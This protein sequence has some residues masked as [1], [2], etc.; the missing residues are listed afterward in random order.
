M[1]NEEF[2]TPAVYEAFN[3]AVAAI[4]ERLLGAAPQGWATAGSSLRATVRAREPAR[5]AHA[6]ARAGMAVPTQR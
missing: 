5:T 4:V 1:M 3:Q 6:L 2:A